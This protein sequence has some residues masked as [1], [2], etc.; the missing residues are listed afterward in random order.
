[1]NKPTK[2]KSTLKTKC[3]KFYLN[4]KGHCEA[5]DKIVTQKDCNQ[6]SCPNGTLY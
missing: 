5:L 6:C 1:M 2:I 4:K 3:K